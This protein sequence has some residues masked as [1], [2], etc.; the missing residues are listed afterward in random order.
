MFTSLRIAI[1]VLACVSALP[2][3]RRP[4]VLFLL[5][6][7]QRPD[8]VGAFGNPHITTPSID[9]LATR[10]FRMSR[11]YCMGSVHGAVCRP[12]RAMMLSGRTLWRVS[13]DLDGV[14]TLPGTFGKA[15]Y[16]TF[17]TGKWHNGAESVRQPA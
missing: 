5:A 6:D 11:T 14:P 2:A 10:G 4:N 12:S 17:A 13:Q 3:Q 15:G 8:A 16:E 7:D 9:G 1:A